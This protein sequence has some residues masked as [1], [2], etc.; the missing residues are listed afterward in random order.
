[1]L[2]ALQTAIQ[3]RDMATG[4]T[5]FVAIRTLGGSIGLAVFQTVQQ[6]KLGSIISKLKLQYPQYA[7]LIAKAVNNQAVIRAS[8]TPSELSQA[9]ID[10]YVVALRAVFYASIPFA[11]MIVVLA[12][13]VRHIPLRTRMAKTVEE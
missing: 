12:V 8:T 3:P 5:L 2:L 7:E 6:N 13:F 1:M 11:V 9:L 10:A 4:T